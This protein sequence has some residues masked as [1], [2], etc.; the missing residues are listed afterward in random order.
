MCSRIEST[1]MMCGPMKSSSTSE[2]PCKRNSPCCHSFKASKSFRSRVSISSLVTLSFHFLCEAFRRVVDKGSENCENSA[3]L[4]VSQH[5]RDA[6]G[7]H[8][9]Q[10]KKQLPIFPTPLPLISASDVIVNQ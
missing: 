5:N 9:S 3:G 4:H 1:T 8:R 6:F 2:N 10:Q 7:L